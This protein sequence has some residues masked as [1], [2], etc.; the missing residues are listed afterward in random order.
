MKIRNSELCAVY[1]R[2]WTGKSDAALED[3]LHFELKDRDEVNYWKSYVLAD[4]GDWQQ[5]ASVLPNTYSE[6]EDYPPHIA[7][8]LVLV[9]AEV[10]LRDGRIKAAK[11]LMAIVDKNSD[12]LLEPMEAVPE[13][14]ERRG[15]SS[16]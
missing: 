2:P 15:V 13:I 5:A 6:I 7:N 4:L 9:L 10:A 12:E 14:F 8:R 3:F 1:Q 16:G 11:E